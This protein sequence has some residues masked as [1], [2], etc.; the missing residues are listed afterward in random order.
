MNARRRQFVALGI[1][2]LSLAIP[3]LAQ[4]PSRVFRVG[5]LTAVDPLAERSEFFAAA[6]SRSLV[7]RG[8]ALD[9]NL[10]FERR[11][12]HSHLDRLPRLVDELVASKV[13]VIVVSGYPA[14]RAA[15]QGTAVVPV[16]VVNAGD[17]VAS[18]LVASLARPGGNLTGI[19]DVAGELAPK[20]LQ[21]LKETAPRLRRV[22]MLWNAG[23]L[24][25]TMRYQATAAAAKGLGVVVQPLGVREPEDFAEAFA[26]LTRDQPDAILMVADPLTGLNRKRVFE[27]AAAHRLPA[28]YEVESHA[29]DGGLM[30]YGPDAEETSERTAFLVDRILKGSRPA[31]LPFEQPTRFRLVV[32]LKTAKALGISIPQSILIRA[33]EIV[34]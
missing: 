33:D 11:G 30:A 6:L 1:G 4:Q 20:R 16:V 24:G 29:R 21:L 12:A 18:G 3:S 28:I 25:M 17:P 22:A 32:N 31:D 10:V 15:K 2:T 5:L 26:A 27:Y 19:S 7:Q 9:R 14:A 23:D 34:E 8:Y 13:D